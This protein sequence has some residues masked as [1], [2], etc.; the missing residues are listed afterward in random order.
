[1]FS[2]SISTGFALPV[3]S[4]RP[5]R[6]CCASYS[7]SMFPDDHVDECCQEAGLVL[8]D[9]GLM[10]GLPEYRNGGLLLDLG[11]LEAKYS[12]V[13]GRAHKPDEEVIFSS[14]ARRPVRP[15]AR[16]KSPSNLIRRF[17][18]VSLS[19]TWVQATDVTVT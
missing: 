12:D 19:L 16:L 15:L 8:T 18:Q 5:S 11:L 2:S 7:Y 10:T 17:A 9:T 13:T 6:A 1:M 3:I 4:F 14:C